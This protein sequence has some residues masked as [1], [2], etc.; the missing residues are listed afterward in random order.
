MAK[1]ISLKSFVANNGMDA[2]LVRAIANVH[3]SWSDFKEKAS[4]ITNYGCEGGTSFIMYQET[5]AFL[6]KH[7]DAIQDHLS[8]YAMNAGMGSSLEMLEGCK[9]LKDFNL[10]EIGKALYAQKGDNW[11]YISW[12]ICGVV[13]EDI[14]RLLDDAMND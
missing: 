3:G 14:A 10:D 11:E 6:K 4:D 1:N 2:K 9:N 12:T 13:V 8:T 5:A 7:A